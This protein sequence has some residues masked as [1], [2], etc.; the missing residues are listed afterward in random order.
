MLHFDLLSQA[1]ALLKFE[2][3]NQ[4]AIRRAI[5]NAYNA[6]F[7]LIIQ[8]GVDLLLGIEETKVNN[9]F[10]RSFDHG[11]MKAGCEDVRKNQLPNRHAPIAG[12]F[13][14]ELV[15]LAIIFVDLQR[16]RH[17]ADYNHYESISTNIAEDNIRIA[18]DA[19]NYWKS[20]L[21]TDSS[22][23]KQFVTLLLLQK[24]KRN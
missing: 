9:Y 23:A 16:M 20:V 5:S 3:V 4:A 14:Y 8:D 1:E 12:P 18:Y 2:D 6:V 13:P 22:A 21:Q 10:Q 24:M 17:D 19:I 15:Q 11:S 7:H